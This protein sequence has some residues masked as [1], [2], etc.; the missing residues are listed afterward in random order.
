M[1][2]DVSDLQQRVTIATVAEL[3]RANAVLWQLQQYMREGR[4][5]KFI[6]IPEPDTAT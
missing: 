2:Y 6:R 1:C 4:K 3:V 5:L